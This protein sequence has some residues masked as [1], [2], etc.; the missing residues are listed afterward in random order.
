[1]RPRRRRRAWSH[2]DAIDVTVSSRETRRLSCDHEDG[3]E[4]ARRAVDATLKFG[5]DADSLTDLY[6]LPSKDVRQPMLE[7]GS[8]VRREG[9]RALLED[10]S[11]FDTRFF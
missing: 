10:G 8:H 3:V 7:V 11:I 9:D 6:F 2:E 5:T 4:A 1:M